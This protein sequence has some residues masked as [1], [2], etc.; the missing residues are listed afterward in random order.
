MYFYVI[1]TGDVGQET[2]NVGH[3]SLPLISTVFP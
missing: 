2:E 3:V 1:E